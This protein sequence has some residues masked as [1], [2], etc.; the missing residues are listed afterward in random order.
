[1]KRNKG[2][3][4]LPHHTE[5]ACHNIVSVQ[6]PRVI[7]VATYHACRRNVCWEFVWRYKRSRTCRTRRSGGL[8]EDVSLSGYWRQLQREQSWHYIRTQKGHRFKCV[9]L[10]SLNL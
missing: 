4:S 2:V 10:L 8:R 1:V 9:E 6:T 5:N 7:K 3:D